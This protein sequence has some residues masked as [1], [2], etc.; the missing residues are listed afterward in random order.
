MADTKEAAFFP[1]VRFSIPASERIQIFRSDSPDDSF[2]ILDHSGDH[3]LIGAKNA[4]YNVSTSTLRERSK[5]LWSS[6]ETDMSQCTRKGRTAVACNNYIRVIALKTHETALI[7]GTNAFKPQCRE[8]RWDSAGDF[9]LLEEKTGEGRCPSDP[10]HN[11]T[12]TFAAPLGYRTERNLY[13]ATAGQS[14]GADP[15]IYR[16]PL[17]T[18]QNDLRILNAPQFVSSMHIG[19]HVYFFFR[20]TAIEY[21]NCGKAIYSRVARVCTNDEGISDRNKKFTSFLKAR[22]NCSI[23]GDIPF[24]FNELQSTSSIVDGSYNGDRARLIYSVLNTGL[25]SIF[26]SAVCAFRVE[27]ISE[28]FNGPFK[29]QENKNSNWLPVINSRVPEPRPGQCVNNSKSLPQA[30]LTFIKEHP[31]MDLAVPAYF[32]RPIVVHTGFNYR[33][34]CVAVD[35]Q[36]EGVNGKMYDVLFI[37][38][39]H[40][41]VVK[42]V[43]VASLRAEHQGPAVVEDVKVFA[44]TK[45]VPTAVPVRNIIVQRSA[46]E[47]KIIVA[48]QSE[49]RAVPLFHCDL[50]KTCVDCVRL[51]DPYCAWSLNERR[52]TEKWRRDPKS[53]VQNIEEGFHEKCG[54]SGKLNR[55]DRSDTYFSTSHLYT[56]ETL[57]IAVTTSIVTS[58]VVGFMSGYI[59]AKRYRS[60]IECDTGPIDDYRRYVDVSRMTSD[61]AGD[62]S[63]PT[64]YKSNYALPPNVGTRPMNLVLNK[65]GEP[66]HNLSHPS[67]IQLSNMS[68]L[69]ESKSTMQK[70]KKIYL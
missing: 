21:L 66:T 32:G 24:Y 20:E 35:G 58:L 11:T 64:T 8:Y 10:N 12:F 45:D 47:D 15:M 7:C 4:V 65:S 3:L 63:T 61:I 9:R 52:C 67:S 2:R 41:H 39:D 49:I 27:D 70:V 40:G 16:D 44:A 14:S 42:V 34:T 36:V 43:N 26:G 37:G 50:A 46:Y 6:T 28:V 60:E 17:R 31:L 29:E 38:T 18:E 5:L 57:A 30:T 68:S 33:Y 23:P 48:S 59:F 69:Q 53:M 54:V 56:P 1:D 62:Y 19:S 13:V 55:D 51:R 22:L 25:N